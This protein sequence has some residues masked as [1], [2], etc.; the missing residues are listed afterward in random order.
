MIPGIGEALR[1]AGAAKTPM[2][3]LSRSVAGQLGKTLVVA[4]PGSRGGAEDGLK[5]LAELLPHALHVMRGG[6]H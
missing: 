1:A 5:V 2:S 6:S 3:A 4:L